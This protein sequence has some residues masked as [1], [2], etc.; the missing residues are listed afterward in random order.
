MI[1]LLYSVNQTP[2][3]K[4]EELVRSLGAEGL[5]CEGMAR[6]FLSSVDVI[7]KRQQVYRNLTAVPGMLESTEKIYSLLCDLL[8][9]YDTAGIGINK[10]S[11]ETALNTVCSINSYIEFVEQSYNEL[12]NKDLFADGLRDFY[13]YLTKEINSPE[14]LRLKENARG[15]TAEIR[16]AKSVTVGINLDANLR[17]VEA[18]LVSINSAMYRSAR[19]TDKLFSGR[20]NDPKDFECLCPISTMSGAASREEIASVNL[21]LNNALNS[22]IGKSF[23]KLS[24]E[25]KNYL[26]R[27]CRGLVG[28]K[29]G[30]EFYISAAEF[31]E[32][33]TAR[34]VPACLPVIR[35]GIYE[36]SGLY[37]YATV[38]NKGL[39]DTASNS[40]SFDEKGKVYVLCGANSGGKSVFLRSVAFAQLM[41]QL[42]LPVFAESALM[43]PFSDICLYRAAK[44]EN[45]NYGRFESEARW[46]SER[47]S[48]SASPGGSLFLLD[49]LFSG[50][51]A[52]EATDT[53]LSA[54][55]KMARAGA[56]CIFVTH[57]LGVAKRISESADPDCF[58]GF[59][60]LHV[61]TDGDRPTHRIIRGAPDKYE[62]KA[63]V[64]AKKYGI[65]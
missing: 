50:T 31:V 30:L 57:L 65:I 3:P 15:I 39:K 60:V 12:R 55:T 27:V 46:F 56:L 54:L 6:F 34:G 8:C 21:R 52:E 44:A 32:S 58:D 14:F 35:D 17:P 53:A 37:D 63:I 38:N 33:Y 29:E 40:L 22:V 19:F 5:I 25:I 51:N 62:S 43:Y 13:G 41:F 48:A 4:I 1:D 28:L 59:D 45:D 23:R 36:I 18:G 11:N 2:D 7:R 49:E 64:I 10:A 47:I 61:E 20:F 9:A 26:D 16:Y 24:G 42:G